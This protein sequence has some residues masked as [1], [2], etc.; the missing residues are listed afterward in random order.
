MEDQERNAASAD[1]TVSEGVMQENSQDGFQIVPTAHSG[2]ESSGLSTELSLDELF[3]EP[4]AHRGISTELRNELHHDLT[5]HSLDELE[6]VPR[7][8]SRYESR[9]VTVYLL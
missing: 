8:H 5:R 6:Q 9:G 2:N 1:P 3:S 7:A 4:I